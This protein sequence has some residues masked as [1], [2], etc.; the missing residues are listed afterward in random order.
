MTQ[1]CKRCRKTSP[2]VEFST[3]TS[4]YCVT[5]WAWLSDNGRRAGEWATAAIDRAHGIYRGPFSA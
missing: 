5:C 2:E 4:A 3:T 1:D